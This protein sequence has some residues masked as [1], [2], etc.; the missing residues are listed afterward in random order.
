MHTTTVCRQE[1]VH[2][3]HLHSWVK[4]KCFTSQ[5]GGLN[6]LM[7]LT[8]TAQGTHDNTV[9]YGNFVRPFSRKEMFVITVIFCNVG[10]ICE[11][12]GILFSVR[13]GDRYK[14]MA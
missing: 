4:P 8:I 6:T 9:S 7:Y 5:L 3:L 13:A 10:E 2:Q 14:V 11:K 12:G 1:S